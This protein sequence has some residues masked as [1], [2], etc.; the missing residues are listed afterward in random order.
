M[1]DALDHIA[2]ELDLSIQELISERV[3]IDP[4]RGLSSSLRTF[5]VDFLLA[6]AGYQ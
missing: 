3:P 6:K 1:W 4:A 5:I 2:T